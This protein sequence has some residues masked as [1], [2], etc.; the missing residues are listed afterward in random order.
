M[1]FGGRC[2]M[3]ITL[4]AWV[5]MV[6]A[7]AQLDSAPP[8]Y[9]QSVTATLVG[10]V[11]DPARAAVPGA[12]VSLTHRDTNVVRRVQTNARG[13]YTFANLPPGAYRLDAEHPG[14]KRTM[15]NEVEL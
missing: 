8:A 9:S 3:R 13:D 2:G 12:V 6:W 10:T 1:R 15:V 7:L 4:A 14:F 5:P 11:L